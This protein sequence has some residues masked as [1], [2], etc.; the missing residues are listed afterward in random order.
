MI[1]IFDWGHK[2]TRNIGPLSADDADFELDTEYVFLIEQK[3]WFR[4][5]FIPTII[6]ERNYFFK[7]SDSDKT[8]PIDKETFQ[9]YRALA[10]LNMKSMNDEISDE[11]YQ[12]QRAKL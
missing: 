9:K 8:Q 1:F 6:T 2:T 5:F 11:E 10:S 4:L 12:N 7:D 3:T